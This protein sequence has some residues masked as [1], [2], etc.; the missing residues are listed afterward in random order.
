M[1]RNASVVAASRHSLAN[2]F[3]IVAP[4]AIS[5]S[6]PSKTKPAAWPAK[7]A[8]PTKQR[9][10]PHSFASSES[11]GTRPA[12]LRAMNFY[13]VMADGYHTPLTRT[14]IADLFRA[15]RLGRNQ[16]C[17]QAEKTEWRTIDELFP[18]L[19]YDSSWP[20]PSGA[21]EPTELSTRMRLSILAL[22]GGIVALALIL[23][24][25]TDGT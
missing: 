22:T 16:P 15:G 3:A 14:Q 24:F 13:D 20:P 12:S 4:A 2:I 9:S 6:A 1:W 23:Y 17:K 21:S 7:S 18:L 19:K 5:A 10:S 25:F 8:P 11:Q